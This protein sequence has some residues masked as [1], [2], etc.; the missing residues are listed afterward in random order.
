MPTLHLIRWLHSIPLLIDLPRRILRAHH[1]HRDMVRGY[2]SIHTPVDAGRY[3]RTRT[4]HLTTRAW[5][6]PPLGFAA[7]THRHLP[8][9]PAHHLAAC[10]CLPVHTL[11]CRYTLPRTTPRTHAHAG[12]VFSS[13]VISNQQR[14]ATTIPLPRATST[15]PPLPTTPYYLHGLVPLIRILF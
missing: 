13:N 12:A 2:F 14:G 15:T 4:P 8:F 7:C 10:L 5:V 6:P 9:L 11:P 3:A 1:A